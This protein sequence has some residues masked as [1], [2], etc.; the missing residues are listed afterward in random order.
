YGTQKKA[1]LTGSVSEVK[2]AE[3]VKSPQPNLS[4]SLAG[5]FSGVIATNRGGEPGYDA[6]EIRIRGISTTGNKDVLVVVDGVPGQL[7][8]FERLDPNDIESVTVLK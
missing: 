7:G 6:S 1:T 8:G 3:L 2:G 5:R 4:N